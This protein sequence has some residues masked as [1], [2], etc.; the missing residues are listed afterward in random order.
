MQEDDGNQ[1]AVDWLLWMRKRQSE[2]R[3]KGLPRAKAFELALSE[4][5]VLFPDK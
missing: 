5:N 1:P 4:A 2:L 3:A